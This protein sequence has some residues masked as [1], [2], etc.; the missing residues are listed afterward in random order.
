MVPENGLLHPRR[1]VMCNETKE[2][3]PSIAAAL[4]ALNITRAE[5]ERKVKH[6]L[7]LRGKTYSFV[8]PSAPKRPKPDPHNL[9]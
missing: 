4:M 6:G 9:D 5:L 2:V 7:P 3:W 1:Q 8:I